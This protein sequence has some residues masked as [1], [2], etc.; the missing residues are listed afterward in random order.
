[1]V[2]CACELSFH[3]LDWFANANTVLK[4]NKVIIIFDRNRAGVVGGCEAVVEGVI[5]EVNFFT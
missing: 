5:Q 1:M 3:S 2:N 4:L